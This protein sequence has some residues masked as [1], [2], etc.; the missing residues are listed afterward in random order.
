MAGPRVKLT[1]TLVL[2]GNNKV[3]VGQEIPPCVLIMY[4]LDSILATKVDK[5]F[6]N[7]SGS[8]VERFIKPRVSKMFFCLEYYIYGTGPLIALSGPHEAFFN[9]A[10]GIWIG[11]KYFSDERCITTRMYKAW[12]YLGLK[13]HI[14]EHLSRLQ[15]E[16][17]T[18]KEKVVPI[19]HGIKDLM[20][21]LNGSELKVEAI[22]VNINQGNTAKN[23]R[24][25]IVKNQ[26]NG[27]RWAGQ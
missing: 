24:K 15:H 6:V 11:K 9:S 5:D 16:V 17:A 21:G 3:K 10:F 26:V 13:K 23:T 1:P 25:K 22:L 2:P 19:K 4:N 7:A 20:L 14:V 8:I 27:A 18:R 12:R